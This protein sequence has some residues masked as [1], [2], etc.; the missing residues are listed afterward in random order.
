MTGFHEVLQSAPQVA[1]QAK[2]LIDLEMRSNLLQKLVESGHPYGLLLSQ[3]NASSTNGSSESLINFF[4]PP[5]KGEMKTNIDPISAMICWPSFSS[6]KY[7]ISGGPLGFSAISVPFLTAISLNSSSWGL[8]RKIFP[9]LDGSIKDP[10]VGGGDIYRIH[11]KDNFQL[12][13]GDVV[14]GFILTMFSK[15]AVLSSATK[16]ENIAHKLHLEQLFAQQAFLAPVW[17]KLFAGEN[18]EQERKRELVVDQNGVGLG[19]A[20][21]KLATFRGQEPYV[22]KSP[23]GEGVAQINPG[24]PIGHIHLSH[25]ASLIRQLS[26]MEKVSAMTE[27]LLAL[28][29]AIDKPIEESLEPQQQE[30]LTRA[31][32]ATIIGISHLVRLF[33]RKTGLPTW[34]LDVLPE[35]VQKFHQ[36]DSQAVSKA[37]GGSRKVRPADVEMMVLTPE[38]RRQLVAELA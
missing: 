22:I 25:Q 9:S 35:L 15:L 19:T 26:P 4:F 7:E 38:M 5:Q 13:T 6:S 34:K 36:H 33:S 2:E 12:K 27:D 28:F 32:K 14:A 10:G 21:V 31:K 8:M 18:L 24:D 16:N 1:H 23:K 17:L 29:S 30:T 11:R 3:S 20:A 37:F